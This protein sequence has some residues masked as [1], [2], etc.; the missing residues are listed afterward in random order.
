MG[1]GGV[2]GGLVAGFGVV[3]VSAAHPGGVAGEEELGGSAA[4]GAGVAL[5]VEGLFGQAGESGEGFVEV[6]AV[7]ESVFADVLGDLLDGVG[8][9]V[10]VS[11][12]CGVG[13]PGHGVGE[14]GLARLG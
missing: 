1:A 10:A 14:G 6:A 3:A 2:V 9:R 11:G 7:G 4:D 12:F 5:V 13:C 8:D